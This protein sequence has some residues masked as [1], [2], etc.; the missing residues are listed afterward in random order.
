LLNINK[1]DANTIGVV[2]NIA[3][4][5]EPPKGRKWKAGIGQHQMIV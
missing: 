4:M 2:K 5:R 3:L 1:Q